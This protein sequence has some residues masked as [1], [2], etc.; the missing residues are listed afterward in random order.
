MTEVSAKVKDGRQGFVNIKE[1][2]SIY[3]TK[4]Q[5]EM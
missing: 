5:L 2:V 4:H 1:F 3:L